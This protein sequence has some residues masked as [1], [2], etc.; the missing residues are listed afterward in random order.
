MSNQKIYDPLHFSTEE[1][2]F[3]F[4]SPLDVN[5]DTIF[6][7]ILID[8]LLFLKPSLEVQYLAAKVELLCTVLSGSRLPE[9]IYM[10]KRV[11]FF[12]FVHLTN[13]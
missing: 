2:D 4:E 3:F 5:W 8:T 1:I 7:S 12:C 6:I 11:V 10:E 9:Q 13:K